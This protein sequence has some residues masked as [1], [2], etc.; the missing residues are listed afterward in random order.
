[1]KKNSRIVYL[2]L[3][4]SVMFMQAQQGLAGTDKK[5]EKA[6]AYMAVAAESGT[7]S[8]KISNLAGRAPY[9]LLFDCKGEFVKAVKNP[10]QDRKGGIS[11]TVT[12]LFKKE[13]VKTLI[14]VKFGAKME[15]SLKAAGIEYSAHSGTANKVVS[16]ILE[17]KRSKDAKK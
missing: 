4:L 17:S 14:A 12:A 9:F 6:K 7:D 2:G 1:M 11:A 5:D 16:D 10:A 3:F 15:T 8:S 13:S